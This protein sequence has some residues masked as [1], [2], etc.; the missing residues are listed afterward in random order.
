MLIWMHMHRYMMQICAIGECLDVYM[1]MY[2]CIWVWVYKC[3]CMLVYCCVC[4]YVHM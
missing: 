1:D 4:E 3:M 2:M